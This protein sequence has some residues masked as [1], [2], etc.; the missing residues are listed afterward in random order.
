[1]LKQLIGTAVRH[2]GNFRFQ[3]CGIVGFQLVL[4]V[5]FFAFVILKF[6]D[7]LPNNFRLSRIY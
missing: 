1:L 2:L 7:T 4:S 5:I 6:A 3:D